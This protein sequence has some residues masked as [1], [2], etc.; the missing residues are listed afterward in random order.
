MGLGVWMIGLLMALVIVIWWWCWD[1]EICDGG[2]FIVIVMG[3]FISERPSCP[4]C[5]S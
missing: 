4:W 3:V 1:E 5:P 2:W